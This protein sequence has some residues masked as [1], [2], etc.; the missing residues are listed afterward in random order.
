MSAVILK[1]R[2]VLKDKVRHD[3]WPRL[4][5]ALAANDELGLYD[6][7]PEIQ[8]YFNNSHDFIDEALAFVTETQKSDWGVKFQWSVA[9]ATQRMEVTAQTCFIE[10][11][12]ECGTDECKMALIRQLAE[13]NT[14]LKCRVLNFE[15][16]PELHQE[17]IAAGIDDTST[18]LI[19]G[20][21]SVSL[22]GLYFASFGAKVILLDRDPRAHDKFRLVYDHLPLDMQQRISFEA[23]VDARDYDYPATITHVFLAALLEPKEPILYKIRDAYKTTNP[24]VT[25]LMRIPRRDLMQLFYY[26]VEAN[27]LS[28]F[29]VSAKVDIGYEEQTS[30][31]YVL[32]LG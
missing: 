15:K 20:A 18:V 22:T 8:H 27:C 24:D 10:R 25:L 5:K 13:P 4:E 14:D 31:S 9:E 29:R 30:L 6:V 11:L 17:R 19:L 23:V 21:G 12:K 32:K 2:V 1:E 7:V 3:L 28:D 16:L 26:D